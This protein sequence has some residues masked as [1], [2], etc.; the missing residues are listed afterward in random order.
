M[1]IHRADTAFHASRVDQNMKEII[2]KIGQ[3]AQS[4]IEAKGGSETIRI[5]PN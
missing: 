4:M 2:K 1:I 5:G 3:Q